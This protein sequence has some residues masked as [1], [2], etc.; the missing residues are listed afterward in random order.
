MEGDLLGLAFGAGLIAAVNP[1]GFAMLP[2]YL[3]LVIQP[4]VGTGRATRDWER[5]ASVFVALGS[6]FWVVVTFLGAA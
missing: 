6:A 2:G 1:C 4:G 5:E 3:S